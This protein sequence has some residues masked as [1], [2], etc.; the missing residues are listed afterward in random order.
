M[1]VT[2]R[3]VRRVEP[4]E[5]QLNYITLMGMIGW[6]ESVCLNLKV[7]ASPVIRKFTTDT[8]APVDEK[9]YQ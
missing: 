1:H 2:E 4:S 6:G 8:A 5:E 9:I 7:C 3:T